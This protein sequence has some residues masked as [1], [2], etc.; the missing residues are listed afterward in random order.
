[1]ALYGTP[2]LKMMPFRKARTSVHTMKTANAPIM[3]LVTGMLHPT[4]EAH[5]C[6][7]GLNKRYQR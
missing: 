4:F 6:G 5:P 7:E 3:K 1:L 2:S